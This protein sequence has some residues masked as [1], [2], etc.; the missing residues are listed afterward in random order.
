[1]DAT[2]IS[3][4]LP[5]RAPM[6]RIVRVLPLLIAL[7]ATLAP[8][9]LGQVPARRR[10][11]SAPITGTIADNGTRR[12]GD[13]GIW[14]ELREQPDVTFYWET[15]ATERQG[16]YLKAELEGLRVHVV[17]RPPRKDASSSGLEVTTVT[18]LNARPNV[19]AFAGTITE[20]RARASMALDPSQP[21]EARFEG[22][23]FALREYEGMA[24]EYAATS[25]E[26]Q[27]RSLVKDLEGTRV[28]VRAYCA[29]REEGETERQCTA[30]SLRWAAAGAPRR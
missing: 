9:A 7:S 1:M 12:G 27:G 18:F 23:R 14:F 8:A 13:A 20:S 24:F 3:P 21:S 28:T 25:F 26:H 2:P 29:P 15:T 17:C 30:T 4:A 19:R 16:R 22:I 6:A 11:C 5:R 10:V